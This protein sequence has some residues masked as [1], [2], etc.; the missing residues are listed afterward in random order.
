MD[1]RLLIGGADTSAVSGAIFERKD[2]V[3]GDVAARAAAAKKADVDKAVET[4]AVALPGWS[5]TAR[6][7]G[8]D[9]C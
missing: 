9:F 3:T 2:P 1:I 5:E 6:T 4:A 7:G 8:A